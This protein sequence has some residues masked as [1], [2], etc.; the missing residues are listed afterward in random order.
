MGSDTH[1][2]Y[3]QTLAR[4]PAGEMGSTAVAV[5]PEMARRTPGLRL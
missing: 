5:C 4:A 1:P 2:E 3:T